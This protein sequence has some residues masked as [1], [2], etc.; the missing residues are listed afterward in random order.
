VAKCTLFYR[1]YFSCLGF[2]KFNW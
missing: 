1:L 2:C